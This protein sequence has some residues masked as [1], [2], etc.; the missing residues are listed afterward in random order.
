MA[1]LFTPEQLE[2]LRQWREGKQTV[3]EEKKSRKRKAE[4]T[5]SE[6]RPRK[7]AASDALMDTLR[8]ANVDPSVIEQVKRVQ[9]VAMGQESKAMEELKTIKESQAKARAE[10]LEKS[11]STLTGAVSDLSKLGGLSSIPKHT[12]S[13]LETAHDRADLADI[14]HLT[15]VVQGYIQQHQKKQEVKKE[16]L[17]RLAPLNFSG[18]PTQHQGQLVQA[19]KSSQGDEY[20]YV[21]RRLRHF[22]PILSNWDRV[23]TQSELSGYANQLK[24][25]N[26]S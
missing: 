20:S 21:Q 13:R 2:F 7:V 1:S 16:P 5:E 22:K 18:H 12:R 4:Q 26:I 23:P 19:S 17:N 11:W 6:P 8:K 14:K 15:E 25:H 9:A 10:K 24:F 3:T